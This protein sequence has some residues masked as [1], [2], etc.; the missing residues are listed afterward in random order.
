MNSW[1]LSGPRRFSGEITVP[2]DKSISHRSVILGALAQGETHITNFLSSEDCERTLGA[3]ELMGIQ[4]AR[5]SNTELTISGGALSEP[6]TWMDM[7]N[8]GTGTR[9]LAGVLAGQPFFSILTGDSSIRRR[10]MK[11]IC[12]PLRKM[13]ATILARHGDLAPLAIR[14]GG[15]QGIEH[16]S[17][18]ASAQVKSC[19]LFAGLFAEGE[20]VVSEPSLSRDHTERMLRAFGA[21]LTREGTTVTLQPGAQLKGRA[22]EIPGDLSSAAFFVVGALVARDSQ[23][24]INS[25]GV[26]PTRTGILDA[27]G[28]MGASIELHNQRDVSGEPVAD[29]VVSSSSLR[30]TEFGGEL[31]P[32]MVDEI[33]ILALAAAFADGDTTI[34]DAG[35]LAMKESN[36]LSTTC[37]A[38]RPF[39]V[40]VEE[41][42]D[43]MVIHGGRTLHAGSVESYGDHRIA[44]TAAIA[45]SVA[46][47]NSKV[48]DTGCVATSFPSFEQL[49]REVTA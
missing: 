42:P 19:L 36:R 2:A 47:G 21:T 8:S 28:E 14:G 25:V 20:T 12:D 3:L 35:E 40:D 10:P 23:I 11:R 15:L 44:M 22:L 13:G 43:G 5:H 31:I 30:G 34:R 48:A 37:D 16:E 33:P 45:G 46:S 1:N 7:G 6:D 49:L 18:V 27:L 41:T 29:L 9:L 4:V 39:G 38:L 26:N 32:R 17:P 24:K